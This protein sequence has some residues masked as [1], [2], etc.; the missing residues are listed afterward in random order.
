VLLA[1][2]TTDDNSQ[3]MDAWFF[4]RKKGSSDE[5]RLDAFGMAGLL[6]KPN[7]FAGR[8]TRKGR[9]LALPL[10]PGEYEL[11]N[12]TLYVTRLGGYGYLSP[13]TL[14][15]PHPFAIRAGE[16]TYLGGLHIDLILGKN[17]FGISM[18][19]GG[20]PDIADQ[21]TRDLL[22]LKEKYPN[23]SALPIRNA[24]PDGKHWKI[25]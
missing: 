1:A 9:L 18:V 8:D 10:E 24:V 6:M 2:L 5:L 13:K 4:Y 3:V 20:N 25:N 23:L 19:F 17:L 7:D 15:P 12:W 11:F 16:I 14:P 22:L 21:S